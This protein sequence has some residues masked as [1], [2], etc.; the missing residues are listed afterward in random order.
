MMNDPIAEA[1]ESSSVSLSN[2]NSAYSTPAAPVGIINDGDA[3]LPSIQIE[4]EGSILLVD[5][6]TVGAISSDPILSDGNSTSS[7]DKPDVK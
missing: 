4:E 7:D 5:K 1:S 2:N 3:T 6:S